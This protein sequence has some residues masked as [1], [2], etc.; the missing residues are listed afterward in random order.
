M[1]T[2]V[3]IVVFL[4]VV[5]FLALMTSGSGGSAKSPGAKPDP[6]S[7]L[8]EIETRDVGE[9]SYFQERFSLPGRTCWREGSAVV[10]VV[11]ES[12]YKANIRE[13]L[14]GERVGGPVSGPN[15]ERRAYLFR[16]SDN[17]YDK[18]VA[19][20]VAM[21]T[22]K[23][24]LLRIGYIASKNALSWH[25]IIADASLRNEVVTCRG[26]FYRR[27]TREGPGTGSLEAQLFTTRP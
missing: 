1:L 7:P 2:T 5:A 9:V 25:P 19:V 8:S 27:T 24:D 14:A 26:V 16:E 23:G 12:N 13:V 15:P 11:G 20:V 10:A 17:P 22:E 6:F 18:G 3:L 21:P 4:I